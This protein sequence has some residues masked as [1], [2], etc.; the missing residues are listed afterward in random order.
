M[1][2]AIDCGFKAAGI[3]CHTLQ[4]GTRPV[5]Y[6]HG[7]AN[8]VRI[9]ICAV[10]DAIQ[11]YFVP[12][13]RSSPQS[14]SRGETTCYLTV[15]GALVWCPLYV[16][17]EFLFYYLNPSDPPGS[18][19]SVL[20]TLLIVWGMGIVAQ[21][22]A[23]SVCVVR[24]IVIAAAPTMES[25]S[26]LAQQRRVFTFL[27][28]VA[29]AS[30]LAVAS[31]IY[32]AVYLHKRHAMAI[33]VMELAGSIVALTA[34]SMTIPAIVCENFTLFGGI[35]HSVAITCRS[36][37][38]FFYPL[39]SFLFLNALWIGPLATVYW[40]PPMVILPITWLAA[41]WNMILLVIVY[42][43]LAPVCNKLLPMQEGAVLSPQPPSKKRSRAIAAGLLA[44]LVYVV[45]ADLLQSTMQSL[46]TPKVLFSEARGDLTGAQS[47]E[48]LLHN[49]YAYHHG[50][51]YGGACIQRN[52][53][54]HHHKV[55]SVIDRSTRSV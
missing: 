47:A 1:L 14:W 45:Y 40:P 41:S 54:K 5:Q 35:A 4:A 9:S 43:G 38:A 19:R 34:T 7:V 53:T 49:A 21:S 48:M 42:E 39:L 18:I 27:M 12:R 11:S 51:A 8:A 22:A 46:Q 17:I 13:E 32:A 2:A 44:M 16:V 28:L 50:A 33:A 37:G 10:K 36:P 20:G 25:S 23:V 3:M 52:F 6:L 30:F 26:A 15:Y 55:G 24:T 31:L 29:L